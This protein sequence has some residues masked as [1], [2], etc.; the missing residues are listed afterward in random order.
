MKSCPFCAESIQDDA[1]KCRYCMEFLD[2]V[3]AP[4]PSA[5]PADDV[6]ALYSSSSMLMAFMV[7][8]PFMLPMVWAHPT[9]PRRQKALLTAAAS[10]VLVLFVV[11]VWAALQPIWQ[12]YT[13]LQSVRATYR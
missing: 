4:A 3:A 1:I 13:E 2:P 8:G 10:A 7:L 5:P 12:L 6:P 11:A 9:M